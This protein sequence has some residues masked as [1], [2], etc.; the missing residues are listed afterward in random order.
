MS[1]TLDPTTATSEGDTLPELTRDEL[2][3]YSRHLLMPE[4]GARAHAIRFPGRGFHADDLYL[5]A[6]NAALGTQKL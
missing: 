4:V 2:V 6:Y 1:A 5:P 3:R